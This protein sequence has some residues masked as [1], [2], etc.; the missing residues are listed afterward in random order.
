MSDEVMEYHKIAG[1]FK[2]YTEG[3]LRNQLIPWEWT[4]EEF[5]YLQ[6]LPWR[7]TE[8]VDGTNVRVVW[9]GHRPIFM[10]RTANSQMPTRLS[11]MLQTTFT[12]EL[13]EQ[14]FGAT[15]AILFGEGYGAGIQKG[16]L[17]RPDVS[18]ILF[19]V[20]IGVW[21]EDADVAAI[22]K[23]LGIEVVPVITT[24]TLNHQIREM[25][26]YSMLSHVSIVDKPPNMEGLVGIP[27]V[28]LLNRRGGRIVVKLKTE[29]FY[30]LS[31]AYHVPTISVDLPLA[32]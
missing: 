3:P 5:G 4:R 21:L 24:D 14:V 31:L 26:Q 8:K 28:P 6:H 23:E 15:P 16:G 7:F 10:G 32:A 27:L 18:F 20:H 2:R 29:D 13:L 11:T 1:P 19:D 17:Y 12:E 9:D 25:T 22:A 30:G